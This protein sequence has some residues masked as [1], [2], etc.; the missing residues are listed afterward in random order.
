MREGYS[1]HFVCVCVRV[2]LCV[3]YCGSGY[4]VRAVGSLSD[5]ERRTRSVNAKKLTA[6]YFPL[7]MCSRLVGFCT[8]GCE[9]RF[10]DASA[11]WFL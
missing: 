1:S 9:K 10:L 4:I 2:C 8:L 7:N 5:V 3:C 6:P 11:A